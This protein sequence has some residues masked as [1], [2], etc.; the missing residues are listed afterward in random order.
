M[1]LVIIL[2]W[3]RHHPTDPEYLYLGFVPNE[4]G[5][6]QFHKNPQY[7]DE[8]SLKAMDEFSEKLIFEKLNSITE[9][10]TPQVVCKTLLNHANQT[11]YWTMQL[12]LQKHQE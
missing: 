2:V 9:D 12:K 1:E 8:V 7:N 4:V 6:L 10:L 3:S 11:C 5:M